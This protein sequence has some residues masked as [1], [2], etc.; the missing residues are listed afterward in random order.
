MKK[1]LEVDTPDKVIDDTHPLLLSPRSHLG[2]IV[3]YFGSTDGTLIRT[4]ALNYLPKSRGTVVLASKDLAESPVIDL[5]HLDTKAGRYRLRVLMWTTNNL[6]NTPAG[7]EMVVEE[8]VPEGYEH[9]TSDSTDE[10]VGV[11]VRQST[12]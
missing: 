5:N 8:A 11:R 7:R 10:E 12:Q 6:M 4:V 2:L 1:D 3:F 9:L